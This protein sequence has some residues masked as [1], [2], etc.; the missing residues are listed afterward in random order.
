MFIDATI[1]EKCKLVG[2]RNDLESFWKAFWYGNSNEAV[3]VAQASLE[4]DNGTYMLAPILL[5]P[6][7]AIDFF[8]RIFVNSKRDTMGETMRLVDSRVDFFRVSVLHC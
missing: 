1:V 3:G 4:T 5:S 6:K 7:S 2:V 8:M